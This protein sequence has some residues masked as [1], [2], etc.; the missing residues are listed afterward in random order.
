MEPDSWIGA[1]RQ[2]GKRVV[3][4]AGGFVAE[5]AGSCL[6]LFERGL[7]FEEHRHGLRDVLQQG[8]LQQVL[9]DYGVDVVLDVGANRGQFATSLRRAGYEGMIVS[10][11]PVSAPF[12]TLRA[13]A[14]GDPRWLVRRL[15]LGD[16]DGEATIHVPQADALASFRVPNAN[17]TEILGDAA[18]MASDERVP[19]RRLDAVLP[20]LLAG[21]ASPRILLKMDT[22]GWDLEV[23]RGLGAWRERVVALQSEV[24]LLPLYD[25]IPD[26]VA[27]LT[28]FQRAGY[29]AA[30][31]FP[32][33]WR[34]GTDEIL[35]CD[36]LMVAPD[37][38]RT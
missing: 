33:N 21:H 15:A 13:A 22:Q 10:F 8:T 24:T 38:T 31:F 20:E 5:R 3:L 26:I 9:R 23:F 17:A 27:S 14:A 7:G 19:V 32:V 29:R 18:S 34:P 30:G 2:L 36:C 35:D 1:L 6:V 25:G 12:A 37:T 16:A 28:E 11:E 4:R